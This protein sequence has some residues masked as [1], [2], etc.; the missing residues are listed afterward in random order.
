MNNKNSED[1]YIT[2]VTFDSYQLSFFSQKVVP[3]HL[4]PKLGIQF[5]IA[6]TPEILGDT[7]AVI[8]FKLSTGKC[9]LFKVKCYAVENAYELRPIF[10]SSA[11]PKVKQVYQVQ[12][13]NPS[14]NKILSIYCIQSKDKQIEIILPENKQVTCSPHIILLEIQSL[15]KVIAFTITFYIQSQGYIYSHLLVK[16]NLDC[17]LRVP[18]IIK[19]QNSPII[20]SPYLLDFGILS[21]DSKPHRIELEIGSSFSSV[22]VNKI[23]YKSNSNFLF[24]FHSIGSFPIALQP[25]QLPQNIGYIAFYCS[26]P[27]I[28]TSTLYFQTNSNRITHINLRAEVI[29]KPLLYSIKEIGIDITNE[30]EDKSYFHSIHLR[31]NLTYPLVFS[32]S[33]ISF[34]HIMTDIVCPELKQI[35]SDQ[36]CIKI[37]PQGSNDTVINMRYVSIKQNNLP[38]TT[39]ITLLATNKL[40]TIPV[41]FFDSNLYCSYN[42]IIGDSNRAI[43]QKKCIDIESINLGSFADVDRCFIL[44]ITNFG[45]SNKTITELALQNTTAF[46]CFQLFGLYNSGT[47]R[48][49]KE[50]IPGNMQLYKIKR[51]LTVSSQTSVLIKITLSPTKCTDSL[52]TINLSDNMGFSNTLVIKTID[53]SISIRLHYEYHKGD[54]SFSP[55]RLRFEPGFPGVNQNKELI[56]ISTF[57]IPVFVLRSWSNDQR[58]VMSL[59]TKQLLPESKTE[60]GV[61]IFDPANIED[62]DYTGEQQQTSLLSWLHSHI[63]L[64]ELKSWRNKELN[65]DKANRLGKTIIDT[66]VFIE[67]DVLNLLKIPVKAELTKPILVQEGELNFQTVQK[68]SPKELMLQIYNPTADPLIVQLFF[69]DPVYANYKTANSLNVPWANNCTRDFSSIK[70]VLAT[71]FQNGKDKPELQS[72]ADFIDAY[73]C[74]MAKY[75]PSDLLNGEI[76]KDSQLWSHALSKACDDKDIITYNSQQIIS[77]EQA[78]NQDE[79]SILGWLF[80]LFRIEKNLLKNRDSKEIFT[81]PA[82]FSQRPLL[83]PPFSYLNAGPIIYHPLNIGPHNSMV[84][85]KNNLTILYPVKLKGESGTGILEFVDEI[86]SNQKGN[87]NIKALPEEF[88]SNNKKKK[89][90]G[91]NIPFRISLIDLLVLT[92]NPLNKNEDQN[93]WN[94][95]LHYF[96]AFEV[97]DFKVIT[98]QM[99]HYLIKNTGNMPLIINSISIADRGCSAYGFKIKNCGNF[100]LNPGE[101]KNFTIEYETKL[102]LYLVKKYLVFYTITGRQT[103]EIIVDLPYAYL[104]ILQKLPSVDK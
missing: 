80:G 5:Q 78:R 97:Q 31:N 98:K 53:T 16:G 18:V 4:P 20:I 17:D 96:T 6:F 23:F 3:I 45:F 38:L 26:L 61:V 52:S 57:K 89:S 24:N 91:N 14:P 54:I 11:N 73:C 47:G 27:G 9:Y 56:A 104:S 49:L 95:L 46:S 59:L 21:P 12:I 40:I 42:D 71:V 94:I 41:I 81:L 79:K 22:T 103:F 32:N 30:S 7:S 29:I 33:E 36:K 88:I 68:G 72:S 92:K 101:T 15:T 2:A 84:Y 62:A 63:T 66:Q 13:R 69:G 25:G 1:V 65:W 50:I 58:I 87:K 77:F 90:N 64:K 39:Y 70:K 76:V 86:N 34:P 19:Y 60:I 10:L 93:A 67:T 48:I 82:T 100:S 83:I 55:S 28:Y 75:N 102:S 8:A 99:K 35:N 44:N 85:I 43:P 37:L 51:K 74:N